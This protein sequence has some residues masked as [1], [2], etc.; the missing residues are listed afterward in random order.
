MSKAVTGNNVVSWKLWGGITLPAKKK[1]TV[2]WVSTV[3]F[4]TSAKQMGTTAE[5]LC[6]R[7]WVNNC[8]PPMQNNIRKTSSSSSSSRPS[9]LR[10]GGSASWPSLLAVCSAETP[11]ADSGIRH[12][13]SPLQFNPLKHLVV[14]DASVKVAATVAVARAERPHP[15]QPDTEEWDC[16]PSAKR[17][18][19][20]DVEHLRTV[21]SVWIVLA[22]L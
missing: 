11:L 7:H 20:R 3:A 13:L 9:S 22:P 16:S 17:K 21:F 14:T 4:L 12:H 10:E 1:S 2:F 8:T 19:R 18:V 5:T 15:T 6:Q